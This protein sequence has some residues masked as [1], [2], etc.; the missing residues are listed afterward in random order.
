MPAL[1][2]RAPLG[3]TNAAT[4]TGEARIALMMS[5]IDV[6][7]PP[8]VSI[9]QHDELRV[10]LR[11]AGKAALDEVRARGADRA[12][13]RHDENGRRRSDRKRERRP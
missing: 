2:A 13:E 7:R 11:G 3:A 12:G 1:A 4:G 6:S 10:F 8:G 9:S 5:R